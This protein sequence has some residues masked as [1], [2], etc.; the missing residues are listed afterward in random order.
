MRRTVLYIAMS[1]DCYIADP[2]SSVAWICGH[3][4]EPPA[5]S[6]ESFSKTIDTVMM[7]WTTYHQ[8]ICELS[9]GKWPY[10]GLTTYVF[11]HRH[12]EPASDVV[13]TDEEP[14]VLVKRLNNMGG[15]DIWICDGASIVQPL[16]IDDLIDEYR[17]SV[18][19]VLLGG[20]TRLFEGLHPEFR[21]HLSRMQA[22]DGIV[23]LVYERR[24]GTLFRH[25]QDTELEGKLEKT[26]VELMGGMHGMRH[27]AGIAGFLMGN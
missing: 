7:G 27:D 16:L 18:I 22:S 4:E 23:E 24:Q 25:G 10:E 9:P 20:G 1:L 2:T 8:V 21:L 13:F 19:P 12:P 17:I 11:T 14:S 5:D 6:Y 15:R 26:P 3:G